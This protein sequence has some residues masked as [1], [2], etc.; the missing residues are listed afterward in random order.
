LV[1]ISAAVKEAALRLLIRLFLVRDAFR[2]RWA[3][4]YAVRPRR[5]SG[6]AERLFL[7]GRSLGSRRAVSRPAVIC[8]FQTVEPFTAM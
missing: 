7:I 4:E 5:W 1:E 3:E 6:R 2:L 8:V